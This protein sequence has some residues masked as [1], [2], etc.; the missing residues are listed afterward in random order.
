MTVSAFFSQFL[1]A[2]VEYPDPCICSED[3]SEHASKRLFQLPPVKPSPENLSSSHEI[4]DSPSCSFSR[5][6]PVKTFSMSWVFEKYNFWHPLIPMLIDLL[7]WMCDAHKQSQTKLRH[8]A[9]LTG[10]LIELNCPNVFM[11]FSS[12]LVT[13]FKR[14]LTPTNNSFVMPSTS[15][16][17]NCNQFPDACAL[18]FW[19]S[20]RPDD[21]DGFCWSPFCHP[22]T[23]SKCDASRSVTREFL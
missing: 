2:L 20:L 16:N 6:L 11:R 19:D 1:R 4:T 18:G 13:K 14:S 17:T 3:Y 22:I 10:K 9:M 8:V 23:S 21:D 7:M 15:I 5:M 12:N